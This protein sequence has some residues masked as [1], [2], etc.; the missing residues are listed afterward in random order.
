VVAWRRRHATAGS[1]TISGRITFDRIR[2][3]RHWATASSDSPVESP[4]RQVTVQA[5]D[6]GNSSCA[7]TATTDDQRQ[8]LGERAVQSQSVHPRARRDGEDGTRRPGIFTVRNNTTGTNDA[9]YALGRQPA[10]SGTATALAICA[11]RQVSARRAT[12]ARARPRRS[13]FST[14]RFAPRSWC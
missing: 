11:Q 3:T 6:A 8:L 2:S 13:R 10:S 7:R 14:L 5:I 1:V 4:A 12:P 9:L